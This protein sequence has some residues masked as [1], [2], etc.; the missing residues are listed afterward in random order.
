MSSSNQGIHSSLPMGDGDASGGDGDVTSS[1]SPLKQDTDLTGADG[2]DLSSSNAGAAPGAAEAA[3]VDVKGNLSPRHC[4]FD[5]FSGAAGDMMLAACLDA[6]V[7]EATTVAASPSSTSTDPC[8]SDSGNAPT[9]AEKKGLLL[10]EFV[11]H[12]TTCLS[13]GIPELADEFKIEAKGVWRGGM[14]SIAGLNVSVKS[15]KYG[16]VPAPVPGSH[17]HNL[18]HSHEHSHEHSHGHAHH[19]NSHD[20][21]H[22]NNHGH[23]HNHS[24]HHQEHQDH[25]PS[26]NYNSDTRARQHHRPLLRNLD[27]IT[28]MLSNAPSQYISPW[29]RDTAIRTFRVLAEAEAV[30]HAAKSIQEVHF[31][32]VGAVDSIV[33]TV[34]TLIVLH[35]ILKC[36]TSFSSSR[37]P[38]GEGTVWTA[39]GLLP[40]PAPATLRLLVGIPTCVGPS[41]CTYPTG[42]LVTPTGAALLRTLLMITSST[43]QAQGDNDR[44]KNNDKLMVGPPPDSTL[45]AVGIGAG[46]KDFAKHPNILRVMVGD[47]VR[48]S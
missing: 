20:Y 29:V 22:D 10:A 11:K 42:E 8:A 2:R 3:V 45:R 33:D 31:H 6:A 41:K 36:T 28:T 14:G 26:N 21:D 32:E 37:I 1:K 35:D 13:K 44:K 40:V 15:I 27:E 19:N 39:H 7:T 34:G 18:Q 46:T 4:H 23:G 5:C 9:S 30:T 43:S 24:H 25:S 12:V 16:D 17:H 38:V 47:D 48:Y